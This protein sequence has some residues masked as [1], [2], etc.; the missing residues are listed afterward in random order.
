[1]LDERAESDHVCTLVEQRDAVEPGAAALAQS[2]RLDHARNLSTDA[3]DDDRSALER[4]LR[5][6]PISAVRRHPVPLR[7]SRGASAHRRRVGW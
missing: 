5:L 4:G 7:C 1:V 3:H 2:E 6:S